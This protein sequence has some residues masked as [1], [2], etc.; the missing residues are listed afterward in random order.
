MPKELPDVILGPGQTVVVIG[1]APVA[2]NRDR[3]TK[4]RVRV[5]DPR[6]YVE[7]PPEPTPVPPP[8]E[9]VLQ[10]SPTDSAPSLVAAFANMNYDVVEFKAGTY[11]P[12]PVYVNID[13]SARPLTV[14]QAAG[15]AVT[16]SGSGGGAFYF[17]LGGAAAHIAFRVPGLVFDNYKI[18]ST[19]IVWMG[20]CHDMEFSGPIVQNSATTTDPINSWAVY[21]SVDAGVSPRNV[22][23]DNWT[24]KGVNRGISALQVGHPPST[25][26][27]I[28]ARRW[29]V[30][31]ASYAIY[32]YGV[33]S[34]FQ[35]DDWSVTNS[36][37]ADRPYTV[38]FGSGVT[39]TYKNMLVGTGGLESKGGMTDDGGN[40]W[41]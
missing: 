13:R 1:S 7:P 22:V 4:T 29:V 28:Y 24:V 3:A 16:F 26:A 11:K 21:L 40:V 8:T 17:G 23:V 20:N 38:F 30:D 2:Y 35:V 37:R 14:R 34:D 36:V 31:S 39:G 32:A 25:M 19:G 15:A 41:G 33:V 27:G 18:G 12:G 10:V 6:P 5:T 9:A